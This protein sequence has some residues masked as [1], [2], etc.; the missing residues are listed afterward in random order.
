MIW[1]A[2]IFA[3]AFSSDE[4]FLAMNMS[5]GPSRVW[6]LMSAEAVVNLPREAV[7]VFFPDN[8]CCLIFFV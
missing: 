7:S 1:V 4:K 5:G 8:L 3:H 6:D 2:S